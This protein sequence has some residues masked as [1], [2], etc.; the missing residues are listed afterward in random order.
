M[1][2]VIL[3]IA[4]I[5]A[6]FVG[7]ILGLGGGI[8]MVPVLTIIFDFPFKSAVGTSLTAIVLTSAGASSI[9]L[10]RGEV[11]LPAAYRLELFTVIGASIGGFSAIYIPQKALAISFAVI[12]ILTAYQMSAKVIRA[13]LAGRKGAD[14]RGGWN[15]YDATPGNRI[16]AYITSVFAGLV[17]ALLGVGGGIVKVPILNLLLK[18]PIRM[19]VASSGLMIGITA[20]AGAIHYLNNGLVKPVTAL[21]VA[22]SVFIGARS[23]A[24]I[25]K[26]IKTDYIKL[27]FS[28]VIIYTAIRIFLKY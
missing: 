12:L 23:G 24:L 9:Y 8:V 21:I 25:A 13:K 7:A 27:A 17:S 3:I 15:F 10:K 28:A 6:G 20:S 26:R 14:E 22:A 18:A 5:F 19:A 4:T 11:S 2:F 16:T 1:D